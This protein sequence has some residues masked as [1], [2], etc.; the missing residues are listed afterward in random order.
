MISR[1]LRGAD[2]QKTTNSIEIEKHGSAEVGHVKKKRNPRG[3][4]EKVPGSGFWWIR[5]VD[6]HGKLRRER[7]PSKSSALSLY[8]KRKGEA[9][10]GRKLPE[11]LR[12]PKICFRDIAEVAISDIERRYRRPADDTERL[13]MAIGWF[14]DREASSITA[15]DIDAKLVRVDYQ[16]LSFCNLA[17]LPARTK[18]RQAKRESNTRRAALERKQ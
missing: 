15:G 2:M 11:T 3:V 10:T 8:H 1:F 16:S 18:N 14:G 6:A 9:L 17:C 13:R 4:F 7:A 5:Y 12:R